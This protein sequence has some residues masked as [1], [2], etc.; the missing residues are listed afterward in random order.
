[1]HAAKKA[2]MCK[3]YRNTQLHRTVW[4]CLRVSELLLLSLKLRFADC[5]LQNQHKNFQS[6]ASHFAISQKL[7]Q[8]L[9]E[10]KHY[11]PFHTHIW[12]ISPGKNNIKS[13]RQS[14]KLLTLIHNLS[15][16]ISVPSQGLFNSMLQCKVMTEVSS[17]FP[18][19]RKPPSWW[20]YE[21]SFLMWEVQNRIQVSSSAL[22]AVEEFISLRSP[23]PGLTRLPTDDTTTFLKG[24]VLLL[25]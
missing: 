18:S 5:M 20:K 9:K 21:F 19:P 22:T 15:K 23:L 12:R 24:R 1:M 2:F 8:E 10:I 16:G 13:F 4:M 25:E 3:S 7:A 17:I 11:S 14:I 6:S